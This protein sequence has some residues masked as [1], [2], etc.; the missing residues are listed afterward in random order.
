MLAD[1]FNNW[2]QKKPKETKHEKR[3]ATIEKT[4][5]HRNREQP[6]KRPDEFRKIES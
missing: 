3:K 2:I 4:E 5:N 1:N 6:V